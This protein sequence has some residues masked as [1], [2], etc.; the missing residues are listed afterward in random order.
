MILVKILA[1]VPET[2]INRRIN[3]LQ[4]T[5]QQKN[6]SA[7]LITQNVD[8]FYY[9]GTM[10]NGLLYIPSS[11]GACFYVKKSV[12]RAREESTVEIEALGRMRELGARIN[13]RF[14]KPEKIGLELDVLPYQL[15]V[16]YSSILQ[17][18]IV[19]ISSI[20]RMQRA[21]KSSFE[22]AHIHQAAK[23]VDEVIQLLPTW[24]T[25]GMMEIELAAKMEYYLRIRGN[26]NLNR[27]RGYN[28]ELALGMVA[29]GAA[30]AT[31]TY[32]DGPAGG[33]GLTVASPQGA[34]RKQLEQAE[35]IFI[36]FSTV[37]EGYMIDQTRIAVIGE[38]EPDLE[39]AYEVSRRILRVVEQLGKP[40]ITWEAL[41]QCALDIVAEA[42][43]SD[44]FMGFGDDQAKFLGHGV[45]LEI[46]ELPILAKGFQEPLE[47]GMVIAVEPKFTFP[48]RGVVG[49]ENTYV[50]GE[51]GLESLSISSEEIIK[52]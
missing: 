10:Q 41:Y 19:D 46:D 9:T 35:P 8:L 29:A 47:I 1:K 4:V 34:S 20:I 50:V 12:N 22:L 17:A 16:R 38:L 28:Q 51:Q 43:L 37:V 6:I 40:G 39:E 21:V 14:G 24:I 23:L 3:K 49:I 44:F 13:E 33:L 27:M 30:A 32:F 18:E 11:G 52:V 25:P 26:I 15:G 42:G 7:A 36:D 5:L 31:P 2:E 48:G 45:G